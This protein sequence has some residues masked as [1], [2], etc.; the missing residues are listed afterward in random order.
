MNHLLFLMDKT[1][2]DGTPSKIEWKM[3][4]F[5]YIVFYVLKVLV[6]KEYKI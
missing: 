2:L 1:K 4:V 5:W 3:H 6:V